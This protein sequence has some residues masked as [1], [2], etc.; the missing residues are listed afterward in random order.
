M[1]ANDGFESI[2][3]KRIMQTR[4]FPADWPDGAPLIFYKAVCAW[5][6]EDGT[7]DI[8]I[9]RDEDPDFADEINISFVLEV[10]NYFHSYYGDHAS[11]KWCNRWKRVKCAFAVL[12]G[13]E[14]KLEETFTLKGERQITDFI[15]ALEEGREYVRAH[16]RARE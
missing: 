11:A 8:L 16:M 14:L 9:G 13:G 10:T 12:F 2:F 6:Q 4:D 15:K 1:K 7:M 3:G 5:N